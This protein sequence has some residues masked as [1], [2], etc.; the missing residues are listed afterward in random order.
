[1][2]P[3]YTSSIG[4][5]NIGFKPLSPLR[6]ACIDETTG[7]PVLLYTGV[8]LRSSFTCGEQIAVEVILHVW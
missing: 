8:R 7:V 2:P 4:H 1:M 6:C 3:I 5:F